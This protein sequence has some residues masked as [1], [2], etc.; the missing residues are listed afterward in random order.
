MMATLTIHVE[1]DHP[2]ADQP[3]ANAAQTIAEELLADGTHAF[4]VR[5]ESGGKTL[6]KWSGDAN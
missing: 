2:L 5:L 3:C 6:A 4:S 1:T